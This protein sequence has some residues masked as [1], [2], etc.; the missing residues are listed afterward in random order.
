[1]N[2]RI[3]ELRAFTLTEAVITLVIIG[4]LA[5]LYVAGIQLYNP[6]EKNW[7]TLSEKMIISFEDA[8]TEILTN[9]AVLDDFLSL[10]DGKD[11]FS[12]EDNNVTPK[13]AKLYRKYLSDV[14]LNVDMT[15]NY[16]DRELTDYDKTS[17]GIKLKDIYSEFFFVND[18]ILMGLRF[19]SSCK[20]SE[21]F[22]NPPSHKGK[23][24]VDDICG[25][26]FYDVNAFKKPNKLGS[27][28]Y[29]VPI[30][31]RGIKYSND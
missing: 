4:F 22:A 27:D 10:A 17:L 30:Y 1:M 15:N 26:V 14:V 11:H 18:G 2:M 12:I 19:Y 3:K 25:S 23:Y 21:E 13:M 20:A 8:S 31:K 6:T 7:K 28:Q 5:A 9:N 29:I 24:K 16:F